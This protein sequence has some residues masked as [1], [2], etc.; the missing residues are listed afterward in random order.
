LFR[1]LNAFFEGSLEPFVNMTIARKVPKNRQGTV[2]G[3]AGS[4]K[5]IGWSLGAIGGGYISAFW[6]FKAVFVFGGFLFLCMA[7]IMKY[8]IEQP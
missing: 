4:M 1:S 7:I 5:S 2:L 3:I 8:G 6:G